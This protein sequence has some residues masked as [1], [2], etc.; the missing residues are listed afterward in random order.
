MRFAIIFIFCFP[1]LV[2]QAQVRDTLRLAPDT[3]G[4]TAVSDTA[5]Q[6]EKP[7]LVK[8]FFSKDYPNPKKAVILS[9]IFPGAGQAYN[10]K[11]WKLPIVYGALGG[12]LYV[13][14]NNLGEYRRLRDNYK[15]LVDGDNTTNPT[16]SPYIYLDATSMKQYRD[17]WRRYV[18]QSSLVLGLAYILTATEAFVDAHLSR[19]DVSD[20]LS[21]R[22]SPKAQ[23]LPGLG[24][25][26]GIG[27]TLQ[28]GRPRTRLPLAAS[29]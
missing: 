9:F 4:V 22:L 8:R 29:P 21:L 18:E 14:L 10:K 26:I 17:Q 5:Q 23:P 1:A 3:S 25:S 2:L 24:I 7:G 11:W 16:E 13:E 12:V 20:D 19:F 15:L 27:V 28:F 6:A